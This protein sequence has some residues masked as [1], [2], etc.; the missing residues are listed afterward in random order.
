MKAKLQ[1]IKENKTTAEERTYAKV[2][3]R[4]VEAV[5]QI[6]QNTATENK[7]SQALLIIIDAHIHNTITPG[8]YNQRINEVMKINDIPA[9]K[10]PE[11]T[12][13]TDLF[14]PDMIERS[15]LKLK[16][17][18]KQTTFKKP[19]PRRETETESDSTQDDDILERHIQRETLAP[20][21]ASTHDI[22]V[23]AD[24]TK[25]EKKDLTADQLHDYYNEGRIRLKI[26]SSSKISP[27]QLDYLILKRLLHE[28]HT[29]IKDRK[30]T[31]LNS[32][33]L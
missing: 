6:E 33:H 21:L 27:D 22:K 18:T 11:P 28:K 32:S 31:R 13:S 10:F 20:T 17:T 14:S 9:L 16:K 29:H 24:R 15:I 26:G 25:V 3:Q 7:I 4:T 1:D 12:N 19:E 8:T 23:Y 30:S 2:A 5:K